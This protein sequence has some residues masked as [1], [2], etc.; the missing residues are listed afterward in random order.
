MSADLVLFNANVITLDPANPRANLVAVKGSEILG[1]GENNQLENFKGKR[2]KFID[3]QGKTIIPGFNDAHCHPFAFASSLLS[4]DCSPAQV[5]SIA[6]IKA[7][8]CRRAREKSPGT[9]ILATG[10]NEF[11]LAEKRHPNRWDL[12]EAAP[13]LQACPSFFSSAAGP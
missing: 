1:I 7:A 12:D 9:W 2:T 13:H 5:Q 11:Y 6:D 10:Y 8:I 3:C 4:I